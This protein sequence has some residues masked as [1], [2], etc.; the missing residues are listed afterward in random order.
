MAGENLTIKSSKDSP[1]PVVKTN[2]TKPSQSSS[3]NSSSSNKKSNNSGKTPEQLRQ[4]N[5][6]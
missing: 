1:S 6:E 2:S 3:S 5:I 4:E